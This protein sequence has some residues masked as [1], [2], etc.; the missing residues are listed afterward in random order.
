M[1]GLNKL[2]SEH[3]VLS[4]GDDLSYGEGWYNWEYQDVVPFRWMS[5]GA[6]LSISIDILRKYKYLSFI[7]FSEF[8]DGSQYL[9][10]NSM[11]KAVA[12]FALLPKWNHY[13][14]SLPAYLENSEH[15]GKI[16][17]TLILNKVFPRRYHPIDAR[18]LGLRI[19]GLELHN[20]EEK[21]NRLHSFSENALLNI[22]ETIERK[23]ELSSYPLSLGIDLYGKCNMKP[24][25]VYCLFDEMKALEGEFSEAVVD[26]QI[27][28][29]Y[30]NFF[31]CTRHLIN[32]SIG[33]PF[34]HPQFEEILNYIDS[35]EKILEISTNGLAFTN[36]TIDALLGK[37]IFLYVS[38]DAGTKETFAKIRNDRFDSIIPKLNLLSQKRKKAG[39]LPKIN[40][41]FMPMK[42]NK[43]DLEAY[44]KLCRDIEA[45]YLVLRPLNYLENPGIERDRGGYHFNYEEELLSREE[46]Q[47]IFNKCGEFSKKYGVKTHNQFS[48]G[49]IPEP[50][51]ENTQNIN[52]TSQSP[53]IKGIE[54][55]KYQ[56]ENEIESDLG[57]SKFPLCREPWQSYYI[58]RRGI[59][60]CCH[61]HKPIAP[62]NEWNTAW[63]SPKLQDIREHLSKGSFSSYCLK[64]LACPIVQRYSSPKEEIK[65][66]AQKEIQRYAF[67]RSVNRLFFR[68]PGKICRLLGFK[69]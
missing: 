62:M 64:S 47:E 54:E 68:L 9:S 4:E 24:H 57:D 48:F 22:Q 16:E 12:S 21:H 3:F 25:C 61:G 58:L 66:P 37:M 19:A 69:I 29:D 33:E 50:P 63:N 1:E 2:E 11:G 17:F 44:F 27:L 51:Q 52:P 5:K 38:L 14:I 30:G 45:D 67:L 28:K 6:T 39:N 10:I 53:S 15:Q 7:A 23:S 36:R 42:V 34:L 32:C 8:N 26:V 35:H 43:D 31:H 41:I 46:L 59:L 13:S 55:K 20:S 18:E 65:H 60:P 49:S 40:M 56:R